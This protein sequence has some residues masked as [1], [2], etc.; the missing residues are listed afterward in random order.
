[1]RVDGRAFRQNVAH[2]NDG[3]GRLMV[4]TETAPEK[5]VN[6]SEGLTETPKREVVTAL[7]NGSNQERRRIA[8]EYLTRARDDF[9]RAARTRIVYA[10]NARDH[11]MTN[12]AIGA[13]LGVGESAVRGLL[14]RHGD[15]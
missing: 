8:G 1:M 2:M 4:T 10:V 7:S 3:N 11:G 12:A 6:T 5:C 14:K 15:A 9:E 13:I